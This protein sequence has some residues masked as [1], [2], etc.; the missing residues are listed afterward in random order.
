MAGVF[1]KTARRVAAGIAI[2]VIPGVAFITLVMPEVIEAAGA[3]VAMWA[4]AA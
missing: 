4:A 1:R 2:G 3:D